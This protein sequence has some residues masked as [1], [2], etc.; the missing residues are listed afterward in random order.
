MPGALDSCIN[1]TYEDGNIPASSGEPPVRVPLGSLE[2]P[3]D[4]DPEAVTY[5][6]DFTKFYNSMYVGTL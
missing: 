5:S 1:S 4:Y 3:G 6:L 2:T